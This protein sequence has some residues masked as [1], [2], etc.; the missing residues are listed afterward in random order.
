MEYQ[1]SYDSLPPDLLSDPTIADFLSAYPRD[2]RDSVIHSL[3][4]RAIR[5]LIHHP[6][7]TL[8]ELSTPLTEPDFR[9]EVLE[10]RAKLQ[11]ADKQLAGL[12]PSSSDPCPGPGPLRE[13]RPGTLEKNLARLVPAST[14]AEKCARVKVN[15]THTPMA[16]RERPGTKENVSSGDNNNGRHQ[17]KHA[18]PGPRPS[19]VDV[20]RSRTEMSEEQSEPVRYV[21]PPPPPPP[22]PPAQQRV[23]HGAAVQGKKPNRSMG[24]FGRHE[25]VLAEE[26]EDPGEETLTGRSNKRPSRR[27]EVGMV[28][29]TT[30]RERESQEQREETDRGGAEVDAGGS[31]NYQSKGVVDIATEFLN[32]SIINRFAAGDQKRLLPPHM[33]RCQL[34]EPDAAAPEES[35]QETPSCDP[36]PQPRRQRNSVFACL[37]SSR[38]STNG[39]HATESRGGRHQWGPS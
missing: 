28:P 18:Q 38:G 31:S 13:H 32:N 39:L 23:S 19:E 33:S 16:R 29:A 34:G 15:G 9:Q 1:P 3:L 27:D 25:P 14:T 21:P 6:P 35:R 37:K 12:L 11:A 8:E 5:P 24:Q 20:Q 17:G 7:P 10:I 36:A 30:R 22:P 2:Q 4:L 26:E